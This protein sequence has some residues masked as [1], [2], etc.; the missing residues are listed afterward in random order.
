MHFV[1]V[2]FTLPPAA[3]G[4]IPFNAVR[5]V[6]AVWQGSLAAMW[7]IV[8]KNETILMNE[9]RFELLTSACDLGHLR[10]RPTHFTRS[11]RSHLSESY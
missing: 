1:G 2:T 6:V 11:D 8:V 9:H 3:P 7:S 10:S 4:R 5:I